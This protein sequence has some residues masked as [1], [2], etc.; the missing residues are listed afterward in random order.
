MRA[1]LIVQGGSR[2][3]VS[4]DRAG[5]SLVRD[6]TRRSLPPSPRY[7]IAA[8]STPRRPPTTTAAVAATAS[9]VASRT[10][11][12]A[13][14]AARSPNRVRCRGADAATSPP[15]PPSHALCC[16]SDDPALYASRDA[17]LCEASEPGASEPQSARPRRPPPHRPR[18]AGSKYRSSFK[19]FLNGCLPLS[20]SPLVR[21]RGARGLSDSVHGPRARAP[22]HGSPSV[23]GPAGRLG[24]NIRRTGCVHGGYTARCI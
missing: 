11:V 16:G 8:P 2:L 1:P 10:L 17:S 4:D 13:P 19:Q 20:I 18:D 5:P 6:I 7:C 22:R 23:S 12:T 21:P 15:R 24:D 3:R 14:L 9:A